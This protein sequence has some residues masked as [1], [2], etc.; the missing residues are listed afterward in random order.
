MFMKFRIILFSLLSLV[1]VSCQEKI[2]IDIP[3]AEPLLVVEGEVTTELDSS[4]VKLSLSSNYYSSDPYPIVK[5]AVVN[6]NNVP[7]VYNET[8]RIYKPAPGFIGTKNTSYNLNISYNNKT[9]TAQ[10]T[11]EPMFRV[12][13]IFQTWKGPE[14]GGAIPAGWSISYAGFDDRPQVKYTYFVSGV[15]SDSLQ[16]DSFNIDKITF[17][18]S[19]TPINEPYAFELPFSRFESGKIF[20]AIFRSIDKNMFNFIN[21]YNNS[22]PDIP[23]PFQSPPANLPTNLTNGAVGYFA[24]Y[25]VVRKRYTVK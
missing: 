8:L 15:F 18:N 12:D 25:D 7:F 21:A 10:T 17:D 14:L 19:L 3:N 22:N 4:F 20:L 1:I 11:L 24:A 16:Q 13:S 9:Y 5:N 6:V 2:T 23:G